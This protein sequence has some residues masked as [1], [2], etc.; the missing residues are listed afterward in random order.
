MGRLYGESRL[1]DLPPERSAIGNANAS[2]PK[3]SKPK[4][5]KTK[6]KPKSGQVAHVGQ[7]PRSSSHAEGSELRRSVVSSALAGRGYIRHHLGK[8][9]LYRC[10]AFRD[11]G[12]DRTVYTRGSDWG[13][14]LCPS[15]YAHGANLP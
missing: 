1:D 14:L 15:C 5:P 11:R 6:P 3:K 2:K 4:K 9:Q 13:A 12:S 7:P 8:R 10:T